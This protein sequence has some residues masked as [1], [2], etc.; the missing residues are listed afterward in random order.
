MKTKTHPIAS[1][2]FSHSPIK[3]NIDGKVVKNVLDMEQTRIFCIG[4]RVHQAREL[5][6]KPSTTSILFETGCRNMLTIKASNYFLDDIQHN[7][8]HTKSVQISTILNILTQHGF[9]IESST[10]R[11]GGRIITIKKRF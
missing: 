10:T 9:D 2:T 11:R 6:G 5:A 8:S 3:I 1:R 7:F 4:F